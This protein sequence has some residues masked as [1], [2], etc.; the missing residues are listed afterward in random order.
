MGETAVHMPMSDKG[1]GEGYGVNRRTFL[2]AIGAATG[3]AALGSGTSA[4]SAGPDEWDEF[5]DWRAVEAQHVW[6]RGYRGQAER[7]IGLTDSGQDARQRERLAG[8]RRRGGVGRRDRPARRHLGLLL[9]R[10]RRRR[11]GRRGDVHEARRHRARRHGRRPS[12]TRSRR[13]WNCPTSRP[14]TCS[15]RWRSTT[16]PASAA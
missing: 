14:S 5:R 2:Q 1:S 15:G 3:V 6:D 4:A 11:R 13:R 8:R 9:G 10:H 12:P 7:V 16:A